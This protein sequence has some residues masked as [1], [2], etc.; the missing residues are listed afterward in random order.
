MK[1]SDLAGPGISRRRCGRGFRYFWPSSAPVRDPAEV[2][3]I[4]ALVIPPAWEQVWICPEPDGHIQAVG[5][6]AAGRRQYLYHEQWRQEQDQHK[7]DRMLEF[8]RALPRI[9]ET[10]LDRLSSR[11]L[12]RDRVLAAAIRLIDLGFFRAGGAEYAAEN[13]TF[14]LATIRRDHVVCG[15]QEL[16]FEYPAK[17]GIRREQAIVDEPLCTVVRS[18]K[19]RAW[20]GRELLA[21]R[22][23]SGHHDVTAAD[24]NDYLHEISGAD[25]T[26]KDFRTWNATVLAAVGLAVSEHARTDGARKRAVARTV[27]EVAGYLGNTPA[28]A[29]SSYIDPRVIDRYLHGVTIARQLGSLGAASKVGE[30]AT[31]GRPEAAVLQILRSSQVGS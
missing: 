26:A 21:W 10:V 3:R 9:R 5:T 18:L 12:H 11:G 23:R 16:T 7:F 6:D 1:R 28:V 14:G 8:G 13:G 25:F 27:Q 22:D 30:L 24:I 4:K 17:G 2:A 20:G 29:R 15:R 19:R 31:Q